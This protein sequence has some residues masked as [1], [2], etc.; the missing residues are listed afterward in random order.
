MKSRINKQWLENNNACE[1]GIEWFINQKEK[2]SIKILNI[3]IKEK[4]YV[5][6]SWLIVKSMEY[7][8]YV[9][10]AVCDAEQE[11]HSYKKRYPNDNRPRQAIEAA[12][13]CIKSPTKE[14]KIAARVAYAA[15][16][17]AAYIADAAASV[18]VHADAAAHAAYTAAYAA[19]Y[20]AGIGIF[21]T[22]CYAGMKL[23]ILKY[24]LKLLTT[25][26]N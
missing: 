25:K 13:K 17:T 18:E 19:A 11:I 5:W 26:E 22:A 15:A 8:Q 12:R 3:L 2:D 6:A 24:G 21:N 4:Q 23:K 7:K 16:R 10:Y 20:A 9:S 14:N 1:D